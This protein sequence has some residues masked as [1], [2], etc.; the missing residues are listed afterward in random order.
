M[1]RRRQSFFFVQVKR[2]ATF[3][4]SFLF[5]PS[6]G[7]LSTLFSS[8]F[9]FSFFFNNKLNSPNYTHIHPTHVTMAPTE[10]PAPISSVTYSE[11]TDI[12]ADFDDNNVEL[13]RSSSLFLCFLFFFFFSS[14]TAQSP[15]RLPVSAPST[16]AAPRSSAASLASGPSSLSRH[17][18]RSTRASSPPMPP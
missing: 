8:L 2:S 18:P 17:L 5:L 14:L 3:W 12:E 11:L 4:S 6:C 13:R 1:G 16:S 9:F 15:S 7:L 10:L